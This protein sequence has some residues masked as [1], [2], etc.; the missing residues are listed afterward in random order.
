MCNHM[1]GELFDHAMLGTENC[2]GCE[3]QQTEICPDGELSVI[4]FVNV[5]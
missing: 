2:L 5:A 3:N 4:H 1:N